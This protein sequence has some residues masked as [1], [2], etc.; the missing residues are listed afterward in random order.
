MQ[1]L[2]PLP[3]LLL[4]FAGC[5][6]AKKDLSG[7][8]AVF[9]ERFD[10]PALAGHWHVGRVE[11][12]ASKGGGHRSAAARAGFWKLSDGALTSPGERNQPLWLTRPLPEAVRVEFTARSDSDSGDIKCEVFG[13]GERH[14]SGYVVVFGG[15]NNSRSVIARRDEH[16]PQRVER[17]GGA[18]PGRT[19]R[20]ALVRRDG[21]L[22][23]YVDGRLYLRYDDPEPL[24]GPAHRHFAFNDWQSELTFDDL[25]VYDLGGD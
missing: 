24:R 5:D 15:W 13:D 12:P 21:E 19:Y 9:E 18:D 14:E 22:R 8:R 20:M 6:P 17:P 1:R 25:V 23:W 3:L 7:G 16:E 2:L 11:G 10:A 4:A